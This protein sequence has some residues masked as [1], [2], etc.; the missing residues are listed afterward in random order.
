MKKIFIKSEII[1]LRPSVWPKKVGNFIPTEDA[2]PYLGV[3][4]NEAMCD[5]DHEEITNAWSAML[6]MKS[7]HAPMPESEE[8][9]L[10][11]ALYVLFAEKS[12]YETK[13][14]YA[15]FLDFLNKK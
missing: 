7:T 8:L 2:K 9:T 1:V 12:Y 3:L 14:H 5:H 6:K 4:M 11:E 13:T 15:A 10:A